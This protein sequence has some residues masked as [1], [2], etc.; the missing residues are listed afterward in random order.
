MST[1]A[2]YQAKNLSTAPHF[3]ATLCRTVLEMF[4]CYPGGILVEHRFLLIKLGPQIA[5]HGDSQVLN[6]Y[7]EM[8]PPL[9]APTGSQLGN[10]TH[11]QIAEA[12]RYQMRWI[13]AG[14]FA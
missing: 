10:Q 6:I 5:R 8:W 9:R 2:T 11:V 13:G 1:A 3:T 4:V 7:D 14:A 12:G